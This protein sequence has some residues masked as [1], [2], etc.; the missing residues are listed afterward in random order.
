MTV[1]KPSQNLAPRV[2][3]EAVD[4]DF[5]AIQNHAVRPEIFITSEG[6]PAVLEVLEVLDRAA[7]DFRHGWIEAGL[8]CQGRAMW[9]TQSMLDSKRIDR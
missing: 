7:L 6:D 8:D 9:I 1:Y 4:L 3:A 5:Q 2:Q